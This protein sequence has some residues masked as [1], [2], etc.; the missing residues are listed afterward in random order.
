MFIQ[1]F[2]L[3][4][5]C[6]T[7]CW[8]VFRVFRQPVKEESRHEARDTCTDRSWTKL[9]TAITVVTHSCCCCKAS[10]AWD[11]L[12]LQISCSVSNRT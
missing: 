2:I 9:K 3:I 1:I 10:K 7:L 8:T 6:R 12:R 4:F 5:D 11:Y